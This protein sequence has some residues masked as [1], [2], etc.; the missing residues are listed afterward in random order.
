MEPDGPSTHAV[1]ADQVRTLP[2]LPE[3]VRRAGGVDG[4]GNAGPGT[5]APSTSAP[6]TGSPAENTSW[7]PVPAADPRSAPADWSGEE[8]LA[9]GPE[10]DALPARIGPFRILRRLGE[11][12]MGTVY[13]AEQQGEVEREVALK[14]LRT[15]FPSREARLRFESERQA[16][17]RLSHP[18]VAQLYEAG[19]TSE[20]QAY[21][22]ME[23]VD[24]EPITAACDRRRLGLDARLAIFAGVCDGVHHAHQK[25]L[26]HRDLKPSNVLVGE[27]E[28]RP[29]P[30]VIDFGI[31]KALDEPS[32]AAT[33]LT[34]ARMVGTPAYMA[35]E[36][37]TA[38]RGEQDL[39]LR[40]DVYAL[41]L[42]LFEL[43][44]GEH[45]F[46]PGRGL[47]AGLAQR[48][49][50]DAPGLAERFRGLSAERRAAIAAAR[51]THEVG[52]LRHLR[53][54]LE[55]IVARSLARD[56]ERRYGSASELAAEARRVLAGEPV[57]AGPPSRRYRLGK[58][59]RR[60]RLAVA[61]GAVAVVSLVAGVVT[62]TWLA[63]RA[64]EEAAAAGQARAEAEEFARFLGETFRLAAPLRSQ[65]ATITARELLD[66]GAARVESD[67]GT[68][69]A[70][71]FRMLLALG[72]AYY[73][74]GVYPPAERL[75]TRA[76]EIAEAWAAEG[77]DAR[78][79]RALRQR[80]E[81]VERAGR[82]AEARELYT[83]ALAIQ[84]AAGRE[85]ATTAGLLNQLASLLRL[86]QKFSAAAAH[87]HRALEIA[88]RLGPEGREVEARALYLLGFA[89][90]E[91]ARYTEAETLLRQ[92]LERYT[93]I[94]GGD[95][96]SL[97]GPLRTLADSLTEDGRFA[98]AEPLYRRA[99]GIAERQLGAS[100]PDLALGLNNLGAAY[101]AEDRVAEAAACWERALAIDEALLGADHLETGYPVLNL[102]LAA[103]K[104]GELDRAGAL[105]VRAEGI[106]VPRLQPTDPVFGW[107]AWGKGQVA[108]A[109]GD[110]AAAERFLGEAYRLRAQTLPAGQR[111]RVQSARDLL[112][113][114]Q[115]MGRTA[116]A[117]AL[118]AAEGLGQSTG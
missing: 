69:P 1:D 34:G 3:A 5:S 43:L 11:G 19:S 66:R 115:E 91:Q 104:Q 51:A 117:Q 78:L 40:A 95:S 81:V 52:L 105:L 54:D 68:Q 111:D 27:V 101:W 102:G 26:I 72:Q 41:G 17:A 8:A 94:S 33:L 107:L 44:V 60:H 80:G 22:A 16:L 79:A 87:H 46:D 77:D 38:A 36:M 57:L 64:Q 6:G 13:L 92:A 7:D 2:A 50:H 73:D 47:L 110:R 29:W 35:P 4:A 25:G 93:A 75:L 83:R 37:I 23:K 74:L 21:F 53:G 62:S 24:G 48:M 61:A 116:E 71:Q 82:R 14:V 55:W 96:Y 84:D 114:L 113:L 88:R 49:E 42:I 56:R 99:L 90:F 32:T 20:G 15:P 103:W 100:H 18:N 28:G 65:G 112:A 109:R 85:D 86:E 108:W 39:D 31:A 30:K 98:E 67:L 76:V 58:F 59:V 106:F 118:A 45:P 70:T 10:A 12:G 97:V 63:V 89:A 9:G